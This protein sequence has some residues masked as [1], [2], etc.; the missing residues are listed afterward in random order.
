MKQSY[1][2]PELQVYALSGEDVITASGL[3]LYPGVSEGEDKIL[4]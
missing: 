4:W 1:Q 2:I 3:T